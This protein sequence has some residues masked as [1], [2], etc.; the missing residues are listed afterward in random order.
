MR[1]K[2]PRTE[3]ET[4]YYVGVNTPIRNRMIGGL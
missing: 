4:H 1:I 2:L 3:K